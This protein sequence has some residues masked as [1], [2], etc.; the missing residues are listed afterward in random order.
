MT[1][2]MSGDG[3]GLIGGLLPSQ[4]GQA[5]K[6]DGAGNLLVNPGGAGS[7]GDGAAGGAIGE[8][9]GRASCRERV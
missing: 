6:L 4:V 8:K 9:I 3:S 7:V 2:F 5:L 1:N